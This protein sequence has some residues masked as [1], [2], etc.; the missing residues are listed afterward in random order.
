MMRNR[1][2]FTLIELLIALMIF[3]IAIGLAAYSFRFYVHIIDKIIMPYPKEG[4][5]FSKL[6][7]A[8]ES[9]FY[10]VGEKKN[11]LGK[12]RFFFFFYGQEKEMKF[13]TTKPILGHTLSVCRIYVKDDK[14]IWEEAPVY[15]RDNDYKMPDITT[16]KKQ[17]VLMKNISDFQLEY[18][19]E[20][21]KLFSYIKEQLPTLVAIHFTKDGRETTFFCK[22]K[23]DFVT[24]KAFTGYFYAPF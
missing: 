20:G 8:I 17:I 13:I 12:K 19:K 23:S 1:Y 16:H 21:K 14:L 7:D 18:F 2:G 15:A 3:S 10:F 22:I 24:K 11:M 6:R 5:N 4:V 9:T